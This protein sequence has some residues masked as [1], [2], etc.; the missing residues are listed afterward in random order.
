[1]AIGTKFFNTVTLVSMLPHRLALQVGILI[2]LLKNLDATL[3]LCNGTHL[4]IW[5]LAWK[6]IFV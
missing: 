6:L 2:I 3:G 1:M 4:I 5:R